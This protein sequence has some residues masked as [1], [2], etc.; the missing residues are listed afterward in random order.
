MTLEPKLGPKLRPTKTIELPQFTPWEFTKFIVVTMLP[1]LGKLL[2]LMVFFDR[3]A[4]DYF[5]DIIKGQVR[6]PWVTFAMGGHLNFR[7]SPE[8]QVGPS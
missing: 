8:L 5:C 6:S 4:T 2:K 3:E 7:R 1:S